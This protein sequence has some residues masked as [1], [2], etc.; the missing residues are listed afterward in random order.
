MLSIRPVTVLVIAKHSPPW[1]TYLS[2]QTYDVHSTDDPAENIRNLN[3]YDIVLL[4]DTDAFDIDLLDLIREIRRREPLVALFVVTEKEDPTQQLTFLEAGANNTLNYDI[5]EEQ[6]IHQ[7]RLSL[8]QRRQS[9]LFMEQY[10]NMRRVSRALWKLHMLEDDD[11]FVFDVMQILCDT[12][13]LYGATMVM[14]EGVYNLYALANDPD[15]PES[16]RLYKSAF[17]PEEHNPFLRVMSTQ[18]LAL[19]DDIR[20]DPY[21]IP[22]PVMLDAEAGL[23]IPVKYQDKTIGAMGAFTSGERRLQ[24]D[25]IDL[26]EPFADHFAIAY[27]NVRKSVTRERDVRIS[28][29]LLNA[30]QTLDSCRTYDDVM[31]K[32]RG[33]IVDLPIVEDALIWLFGDFIQLTKPV[34]VKASKPELETTFAEIYERG[35]LGD[36]LDKLMQDLKPMRLWMRHYQERATQALFEQMESDYLVLVPIADAT[37]IGGGVALKMINSARLTDDDVY[38]LEGLMYAAL[39]AIQRIIFIRVLSERTQRMEL[40][41]RSISEGMFFVDERDRVSFINPQFT[42]LTGL[43]P[44]EVVNYT[45]EALLHRLAKASEDY[46]NVLD[47]LKEAVNLLPDS[48]EYPIVELPQSELHNALLIELVAVDKPTGTTNMT[49]IGV[50]RDNRRSGGQTDIPVTERALDQMVDH[51]RIPEKQLRG[52]VDVLLEQHSTMNVNVRHNL[53]RQLQDQL[54]QIDLM[55]DN[56]TQMQRL[57]SRRFVLPEG[58]INLFD[59]MQ[60]IFDRRQLNRLYRYFDFEKPKYPLMVQADRPSLSQAFTNLYVYLLDTTAHVSRV[61]VTFERSQEMITVKLINASPGS[62]VNDLRQGLSD[63][64]DSTGVTNDRMFNLHV[65]A[66]IIG[67]HNGTITTQQASDGAF[68]V[69]ITLPDVDAPPML[70]EDEPIHETDTLPVREPIVVD[71][72]RDGAKVNNSQNVYIFKGQS[73]IV[74]R[75]SNLLEANNYVL[76]SY[77]SYRDGLANLN[78]TRLGLIVV[79][80]SIQ[81]I[82]TTEL[83]KMISDK[84][85]VPIVVI[86]D[87]EEAN[88]EIELLNQGADDYITMPITDEQ[89]LARVNVIINRTQ[90]LDRV[91]E[92]MQAGDL[93]IDFSRRQVYLESN[94]IELTRIEYELLRVLALNTGQV[95]THKQLLAKVWG[96][97]YRDETHYLWVNISRLR[98]KIEEDPSSPRYVQN[99]PGIGYM[100]SN[101]A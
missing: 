92:P 95:L 14:D 45:S 70:E 11:T 6:L 20:V 43:Q 25:D 88:Q 85:S 39:Y 53:L 62:A 82:E 56:V 15:L 3:K 46:N 28:Q 86:G 37:I 74:Q 52:T 40:I 76:M 18:V 89:L 47:D 51:I 67:M 93:T 66:R 10:H 81:G 54:N 65:A 94:Q 1:V 68:M 83:C 36:I 63:S 80:A 69:S 78:M 73:E 33:L 9:S 101:E 91:Q 17:H 71:D 97:E 96:P 27:T 60:D 23:I 48:E 79:D 26:L 99:I 100:F 31:D 16:E 41:L 8:R 42:E 75:L 38:L 44:S 87:E 2:N 22:P 84:T 64:E 77:L 58:P 21:Y 12:L 19:Y 90:L 32:L 30:W 13:R 7:V 34:V 59:L 72:K 98:R 24:Y 61:S 49:W 35:D 55:W 57:E 4:E 29:H 5:G 50:V